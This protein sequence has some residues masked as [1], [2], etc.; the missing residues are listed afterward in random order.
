LEFGLSLSLSLKPFLAKELVL[1]MQFLPKKEPHPP[2]GYSNQ[3][4]SF[5]GT[6]LLLSMHEQSEL[7]Q[8]IL[9]R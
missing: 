9:R 2:A 7:Q 5:S 4:R 1:L 8:Q 6:W 3:T